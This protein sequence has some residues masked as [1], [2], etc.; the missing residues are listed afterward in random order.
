MAKAD[1]GTKRVCP[2]C[3]TRYYDFG[4]MPPVCPNCG[5]VYNP[6]MT[7]KSRRGKPVED[8]VRD[9]A[10]PAAVN[11]ADLEGAEIDETIGEDGEIDEAL[12]DGDDDVDEGDVEVTKNDED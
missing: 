12:L 8:E 5:S 6:Q 10:K 9:T 4:K 1:W 11:E 3:A 2:N 7:L